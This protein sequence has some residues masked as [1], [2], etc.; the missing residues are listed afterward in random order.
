MLAFILYAEILR[1][2]M[3]THKGI[4][5]T[6]MQPRKKTTSFLHHINFYFISMLL[7]FI[8]EWTGKDTNFMMKRYLILVLDKLKNQVYTACIILKTAVP[9]TT[10][11]TLIFTL[12]WHRLEDDYKYLSFILTTY[13]IPSF[14]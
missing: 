11:F 6:H 12:D 9:T 1:N 4:L 10:N 13:L 7:H 14:F 2:H 3:N 8:L 5:N